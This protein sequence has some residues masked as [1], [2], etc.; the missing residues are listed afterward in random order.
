MTLLF[1][2]DCFVCKTFSQT[3]HSI[4]T[5]DISRHRRRHGLQVRR[6]RLAR[7][8]VLIQPRLSK[9]NGSR[10]APASTMG[11]ARVG[12]NARSYCYLSK[13]TLRGPLMHWLHSPLVYLN[14]LP[15][16]KVDFCS[17]H[18]HP[19]SSSITQTASTTRKVG[20]PRRLLL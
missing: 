16:T 15:A 8:K 7:W 14:I 10:P 3:C 17:Q 1:S 12:I 5:F 13:V 20:H 11:S 6:R 19:H 9:R 2:Q 18:R 4:R